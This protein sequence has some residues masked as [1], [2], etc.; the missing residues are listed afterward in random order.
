MSQDETARIKAVLEAILEPTLRAHGFAG[1][2]LRDELDLRRAG[3]LD[4]LGFVQLIASLETRLGRA[5]DL[6]E[7]D[8][9]QLTTVGP[10]VRHIA[11][12]SATS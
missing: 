7:L 12:R 5:V 11:L 10:L 2:G 8:P 9:E 3:L 1:A 6:A 4:S